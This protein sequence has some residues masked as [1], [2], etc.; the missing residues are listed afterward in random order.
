MDAERALLAALGGDCHSRGRRARR[1]RR[2][3]RLRAEILSADG[4]EVRAG[5][6]RLDDPDAPA[7]LA[8]RCSM[9]EPGAPGTVR[10]MRPLVLVLSP[11]GR[12]GTAARARAL[13]L[14]PVVAPLFSVHALDWTPPR[15]RRWG[16]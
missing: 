11:G 2:R 7:R 3:R 16:R 13:G 1:P 14:E 12:E 8:A 9:R 4:S 15:W 6:I 5:D 10:P